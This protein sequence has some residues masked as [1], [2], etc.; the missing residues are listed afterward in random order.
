MKQAIINH[1]FITNK[2]A[3]ARDYVSSKRDSIIAIAA[4]SG[5]VL[6]GALLSFYGLAV[7]VL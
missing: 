3:A 6:I 4:I 1:T 7:G 2:K 5:F